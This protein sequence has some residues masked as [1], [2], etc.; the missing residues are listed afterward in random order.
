MNN[1]EEDEVFPLKNFYGILMANGFRRSGDIFY[2]QE[3]K[4]CSQCIPIR[5]SVKDF[6]ISKSQ[7]AVCRKNQDLEIR[8]CKGESDWDSVNP[9]KYFIY[10]DSSIQKTVI[11]YSQ[12]NSKISRFI[13]DEKVLMFRSYSAHTHNIKMSFDEAK[14]QLLEMH[15]GYTGV[16]DMEYYLD[17]KLVA[18]GMIDFTEDANGNIN[19]LSSN[20]FYY[21]V[22]NENLKRS[23][24]VFSVLK[25]IELC[26][27]FGCKYYYLGLYLP[28]CKKMNYKSNYKPYQLLID[29]KWID[30][31]K[32][33]LGG[34]A[35]RPE[36]S[37]DL[38]Q[39]PDGFS[40]NAQNSKINKQIIY[41]IP[42]PAADDE[43]NNDICLVTKEIDLQLLYSAYMQGVFPWFN[44]DE[45][46]PVIWYS[47]DPRFVIFTEKL[48]IPKSVTK[49]LKHSPYTYTMDK[50]FEQ[51]I[52]ECRNM[53]RKD[54]N[55]TWIGEKMIKAYTD[56][57]KEGLAHSFE[58]WHNG[59]LVGGF[60][61]VLIGSIFCGESMFTIEPNSSKSAFA[62][63]AKTFA[64]CG[65]KII[66]CQCYTDNMARY[67]AEEIPREDFL[68]L[69][70][71]LLFNPL[72]E[73]LKE[74]F[75]QQFKN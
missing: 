34:V 71:V 16:F 67:N 2:N 49:F 37:E 39:A 57:H 11:S 44:E 70:R 1:L 14:Q 45:Q 12:I 4:T 18:V 29:G 51:V 75:E 8:L 40:R 63:F 24:G 19:A 10:D 74:K 6:K 64:E 20:Y 58:A 23:L 21:D 65:G 53:N 27:E 61:G 15:L 56:L 54:Q 32:F 28:D 55:G 22:S 73:D 60:Y 35:E 7:K 72:Q 33:A 69:E 59:K 43:F 66:D 42:I 52:R 62:L 46:Q 5:L 9:D 50:A 13:T 41:K 48:H 3:C 47:P 30:G 26:R 38:Q 31:E 36:Q 17:D 25:E 68:Q